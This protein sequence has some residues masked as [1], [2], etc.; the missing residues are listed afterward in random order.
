MAMPLTN[1]ERQARY[2]EPH[3]DAGEKA[4]IQ[5]FLGLHARKQLDRLARHK[6]Y[7]VT[8][9]IEEWAAERRATSRLSGK[10]LKRYYDLE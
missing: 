7:S 9:P 2:R 6:R 3:L 10:T 8:A 5:L 4:R 1:A